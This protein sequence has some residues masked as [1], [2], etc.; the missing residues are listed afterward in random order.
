MQTKNIANQPT[1]ILRDLLADIED[2]PRPIVAR[3]TAYPGGS[4]IPPHRH[5]R[6]QLV[7]APEGVMTVTTERGMWVVP[8]Q[9]AVWVPALMTHQIRATGRLSMRSRIHSTRYGCRA[10]LPNAASW[11]CRRYSGS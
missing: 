3:A 11:R 6:A 8:P 1:T 4:V 2:V 7:Y 10:S 9:R 5:R